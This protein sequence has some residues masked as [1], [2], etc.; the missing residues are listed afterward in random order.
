VV[1]DVDRSIRTPYE[2]IKGLSR[3]IY[4]SGR[5]FQSPHS[6]HFAPG[7]SILSVVPAREEK[8]LPIFSTIHTSLLGKK[9][10]IVEPARKLCRNRSLRALCR[11]LF[12]SFDE[13][14]VPFFK[15]SSC[16][17]PFAPFYVP[18]GATNEGRVQ[19]SCKNT[20]DA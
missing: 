11:Q 14:S 15:V 10:D 19:V 6:H 4:Q 5:G 9:K 17:D 20:V 7:Y 16:F 1:V 3:N 12:S 2:D 13:I 8:S 18:S